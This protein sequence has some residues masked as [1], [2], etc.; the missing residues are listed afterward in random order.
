MEKK[1]VIVSWSSGKDS[2]FMLYQL[3]QNPNYNVVGL[4][5][6]VTTGYERVAMHG[7]RE[8][9]LEAQARQM[10]L[11][12]YKIQIPP[13]CPNE[14][15]QAIMANTIEKLEEMR[16]AY[17]A[18]GDL[19]LEDIKQYRE[20]QLENTQ[21]EPL[22]PLW[23]RP[24]QQLAQQYLD[25]GFKAVV[26][27]VDPKQIPADFVGQEYNQ[28]FINRLPPSADLCGE[29]GEFHTF[30]YDGPIFVEAISITKGESVLRDGFWF[31]D[32]R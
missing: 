2:A 22:F 26:T 19:F 16:V 27:C 31:C 4:L 32:Y 18:F 1:K 30:V 15:Y 7:V 12:L 17:M 10:N 14:K 20:K 5:T 23:Q 29:N 21:L 13:N 25:G 9:L 8:S 28:D 6:T 3:L 11:P 24:T